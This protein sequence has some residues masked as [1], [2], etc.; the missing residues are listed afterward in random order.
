MWFMTLSSNLWVIF[1]CCAVQQAPF[2][3][4]GMMCNPQEHEAWMSSV[5]E[6][7]PL[8]DS[9]SLRE[10]AAVALRKGGVEEDAKSRVQ[11]CRLMGALAEYMVRVSVVP[12]VKVNSGANI[13][14]Y[15]LEIICQLLVDLVR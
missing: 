11:S 7:L 10:I 13:I 8:L 15:C 4:L 5:L 14:L 2:S 1:F 12:T 9:G 3:S 6:L